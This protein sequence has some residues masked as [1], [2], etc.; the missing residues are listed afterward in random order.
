MCV[1]LNLFA[2]GLPAPVLGFFICI[3]ARVFNRTVLCKDVAVNMCIRVCVY[4]D[5]C[6]C[7]C[8][9]VFKCVCNE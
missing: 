7:A 3:H 8:F 6:L 1:Y 9:H 4:M 2:G 5:K